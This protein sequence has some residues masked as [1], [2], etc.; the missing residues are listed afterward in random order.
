M[1]IKWECPACHHENVLNVD[2]ESKE[3]R[4]EPCRMMT[5]RK[6]SAINFTISVQSAAALTVERPKELVGQA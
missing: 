6:V 3:G 5:C 1:F 4:I 2:L